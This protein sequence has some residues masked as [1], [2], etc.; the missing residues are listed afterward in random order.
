MT[1]TQSQFARDAETIS[2]QMLDVTVEARLP[3]AIRFEQ[4]LARREAVRASVLARFASPKVDSPM[5]RAAWV[6]D[7]LARR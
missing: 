4:F 2:E 3:E 1:K 5:R 7:A 6:V